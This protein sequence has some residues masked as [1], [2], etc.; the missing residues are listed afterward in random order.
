MRT[1]K[2]KNTNQNAQRGQ[3]NGNGQNIKMGQQKANPRQQRS[4]Q[5][6]QNQKKVKRN[7]Y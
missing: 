2:S 7:N 4:K 1:T 5:A 6:I 3:G